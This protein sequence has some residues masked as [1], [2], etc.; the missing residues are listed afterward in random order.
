MGPDTMK[1]WQALHE[2]W[3]NALTHG[4][5]E[6][7]EKAGQAF[8]GKPAAF[9]DLFGGKLGDDVGAATERFL[10]GS[11]QFLDWVDRFS[12]QVA[13]RNAPPK[14]AQDWV[15]A[16]KA[17]AGPLLEGN[18]PFVNLFQSMASS[19]AKGFEHFFTGLKNPMEQFSGE[20]KSVLGLPAFGF[21]RER[22]VW[23]QS[24][25]K[26]WMDYQEA[27]SAYNALMLKASQDSLVRLQKKIVALEKSGTKV[28][29]LRALYDLW[30]DAQEDAY[31]DVALS[32]DFRA[33]YGELVNRQMRVRKLVQ[34]EIERVGTQFGMPTRSELN[35]VHQRL[36]ESRRQLR[37][38]ED[39]LAALEGGV[40]VKSAPTPKAAAAAPKRASTK[41]APT[42]KAKAAAVAKSA[43]R[44]AASN[45]RRRLA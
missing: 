13:G 15:D 36:A 6:F 20:V 2:Q 16:I 30:V 4:A 38:L 39:R 8:T 35:S 23:A 3:W 22:Q 9:G 29:S 1:D 25:S 43:T 37:S 44:K 34:D 7:A 17:A 21:T 42:T 12:G 26:G 10:S 11:K 14:S 5:T 45:A 41:V 19:E 33:A 27:M 32:Q 24:L 40:A 18:N 31:A 28:E